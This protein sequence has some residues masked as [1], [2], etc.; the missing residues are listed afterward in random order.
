VGGGRAAGAFCPVCGEVKTNVRVS[1]TPVF[2][3]IVAAKTRRRLGLCRLESMG[4]DS[5][6]SEPHR[7]GFAPAQP[8]R[9]DGVT[10][11]TRAILVACA[12]DLWVW[13]ARAC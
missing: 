2:T 9:R 3:S 10:E 6:R 13:S 7:F 4:S 12:N 1:V 11:L 8:Y 5:T